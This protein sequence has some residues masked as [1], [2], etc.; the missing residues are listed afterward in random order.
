MLILFVLLQR[1]AATELHTRKSLP[2]LSHQHQIKN[3]VT[4]CCSLDLQCPPKALV[5][6]ACLQLGAAGRCGP[7]KSEAPAMMC[8][9]AIGSKHRAKT[10]AYRPESPKPWAIQKWLMHWTPSQ[11]IMAC[12]WGTGQWCSIINDHSWAATT[13]VTTATFES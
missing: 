1:V 9:P 4:M 3:F 5:L 12:L 11:W 10:Q 8:S 6:K 13:T 7:F 2:S